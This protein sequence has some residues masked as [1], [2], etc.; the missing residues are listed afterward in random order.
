MDSFIYGGPDLATVRMNMSLFDYHG[1]KA[2]TLDDITIHKIK[3]YIYFAV[4]TTSF[5]TVVWVILKKSPH[6]MRTYKFLLLHIVIWIYLRDILMNV[7]WMPYLL[8]PAPGGCIVG[9]FKYFGESVGK[10]MCMILLIF[11]SAG[12][13]YSCNVA[14]LYR[15][16]AFNAAEIDS[17]RNYSVVLVCPKSGY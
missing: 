8:S 3:L 11:T 7:L 5:M 9:V 17:F 2:I 15:F 12:T 4:N 14:Q 13:G 1:P 10:Q 16:Y 6:T